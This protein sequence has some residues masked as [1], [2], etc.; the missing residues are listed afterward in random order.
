S[1]GSV[2]GRS[3]SGGAALIALTQLE[4][5][6][7]KGVQPRIVPVPPRQLQ[8]VGADAVDA[9]RM[10]VLAD[11]GRVHGAPDRPLA[12]AVR[13]GT[14]RAERLP[15]VCGAVAVGQVMRKGLL[16]TLPSST[17]VGIRGLREKRL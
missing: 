8:G 12:P 2:G 17:G 6:H 7:G 13:A 4:P 1:T 11:R 15:G 9:H 3:G 5:Q 16:T 10:D 14:G